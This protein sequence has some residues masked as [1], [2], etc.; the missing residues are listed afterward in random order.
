MQ[1]GIISADKQ[2]LYVDMLAACGVRDVFPGVGSAAELLDAS[3][4]RSQD[5]LSQLKH[6][7]ADL[8][9]TSYDNINIIAVRDA[10]DTP[11]S[12]DVTYAAHGSPYYTP[13]KLDALVSMNRREVSN[14]LVLR[15][16]IL[17]LIDL[18]T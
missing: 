14:S 5:K 17:V 8:L 11:G 18:Y 4:S 13:E 1:I 6:K 10:A 12:V 9:E 3:N 16:I 2:V 7:L 15:R